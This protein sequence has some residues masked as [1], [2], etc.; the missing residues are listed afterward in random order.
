MGELACAHCGDEI[1]G[2]PV[3]RGNRVF[4]TEACAFEAGRSKDCGGRSDS[5]SAP[6]V[7]ELRAR[8]DR[9]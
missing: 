2:E 7:V 8:P 3:R 4:C 5:V 1:D 9:D 6:P